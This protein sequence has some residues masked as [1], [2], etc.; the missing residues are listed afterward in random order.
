MRSPRVTP[1]LDKRTLVHYL[2]GQGLRG[3][4]YRRSLTVETGARD[5]PP[6]LFT[7]VIRADGK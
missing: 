2:P 6:S 4:V 5:T 7:Q 1:G 3:Q